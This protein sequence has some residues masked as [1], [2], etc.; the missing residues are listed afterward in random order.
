VKEAASKTVDRA[1]ALLRER[2][3]QTCARLGDA[4]WH[5]GGRGNCSCPYARPAGRL[6]HHMLALGLVERRPTRDRILW[7]AKGATA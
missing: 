4:L 6:L 2:G 7:A 1:L 5:K 3:P